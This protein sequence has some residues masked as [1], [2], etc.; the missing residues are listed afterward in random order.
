MLK[1]KLPILR[2]IALVLFSIGIENS[3]ARN[4]KDLP[5]S[6]SN[7]IGAIMPA[8]LFVFVALLLLYFLIKIIGH[9]MT[10]RP[11]KRKNEWRLLLPVSL[12][13]NCQVKSV[14][15]L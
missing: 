6:N 9:I 11:G 4:P 7:G 13:K 5:F 3:N 8:F 1:N 2:L 14:R 12:R 10:I 15:Q